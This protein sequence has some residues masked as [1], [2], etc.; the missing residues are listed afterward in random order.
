MCKKA[1]ANPEP[2]PHLLPQPVEPSTSASIISSEPVVKKSRR[3]GISRKH[4]GKEIISKLSPAEPEDSIE[5]F[6]DISTQTVETS[7]AREQLHAMIKYQMTAI[8][9]KDFESDVE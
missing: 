3:K 4:K 9:A 7:F 6:K 8:Q 5:L 2:E 1:V